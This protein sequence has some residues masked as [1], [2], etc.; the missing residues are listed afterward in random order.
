LKYIIG[1]LIFIEFSIFTAIDKY[2]CIV[3]ILLWL[4]NKFRYW[5]IYVAAAATVQFQYKSTK[6]FERCI[7]FHDL[8]MQC[9]NKIQFI[10]NLHNH[11]KSIKKDTN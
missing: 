5:H 7:Y 3:I 2:F 4:S 6:L 9:C 8:F 1:M 11:F 10:N